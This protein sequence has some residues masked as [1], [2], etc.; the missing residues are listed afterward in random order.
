MFTGI[1]ESIAK[2]EDIKNDKGNLQI[3]YKSS[4]AKELKVDQSVCHDGACLTIIETNG[5][6]YTVDAIAE[7]I[8]RTN[9]AD[10]KIGDGVNIERSMAVNSRFDGHIVQGHID[11]VGVCKSISEN[12]GSWVFEFE[13]SGKNITVEKGSITVN[14]VSLTI[15]KSQ[16]TLLSVAIIP[17]TFNN[18]NFCELK[19]GSKVNLEFDILGKYISKLIKNNKTH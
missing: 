1:I 11:E 8:L 6:H 16:E 9:L 5:D 4:I 15:V 10:L 13:H 12:R 3:T 14:G 7:T 2:V 17:Y 19:V 18:T